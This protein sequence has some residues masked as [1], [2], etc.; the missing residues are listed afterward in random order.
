MRAIAP[1]KLVFSG[2]YSVLWGA[3]AIVLATDRSAIADSA[4]GA[5]HVSEEVALAVARGLIPRA[6]HVDVSALRH[7]DA[8][9]SS[10]KIG[11]GSSSAILLATL[12]AH[13]GEPTSDDQRRALFEAALALHREAQGGGSGIDVAASTFG[14]SLGFRLAAGAPVV[15]PRALPVGLVVRVFA[16]REAA[17]TQSFLRSVR[18]FERDEPARFAALIGAAKDGAARA[19]DAAAPSELVSALSA[20]RDALA[21]LGRAASVA[22]VTDDVA[23]L[24]PIADEEA[25]FFGP[26]G[27]GGGDIAFYCGASEP[28]GGF[29]AAAS[30]RGYELLTCGVSQSGARLLEGA[31]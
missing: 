1:G 25:A 4:R 13:N 14:G 10:R 9:G 22:I 8:A 28:S 2:A 24:I 11:L 15:R 23:A 7:F 31:A 27:A 16:A 12:V 19:I 6:C 3:E 29:V 21:A 17:L 18:A 26:S 20:Q 5:T 30:S